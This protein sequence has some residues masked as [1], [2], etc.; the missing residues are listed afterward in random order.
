MRIALFG[1]LH[2]VKDE[3]VQAKCLRSYELAHP[4]ARGWDKGQAHASFWARFKVEKVF[5]FVSSAL[6]ALL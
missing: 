3:R 1:T 2:V 4:D 6:G 5:A